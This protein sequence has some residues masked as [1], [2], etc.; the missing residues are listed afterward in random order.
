VLANQ[1][2][3]S[4]VMIVKNGLPY[5]AEALQSIESQSYRNFELVIQDGASTDGTLDALAAARDRGRIPAI[6]TE[7]APDRGVADAFNKAVN[8]CNGA[9]IGSIDADNLLEPTCLET[10]VRRFA[11][12]PRAAVIYGAQKMVHENGAFA[13]HFH[14]GPFNP[15]DVLDCRL[16]PPFGSSFFRK[17][18][19]AQR[20]FSDPALKTC[21]DFNIWLNYFDC[22]VVM[23][24]DVLVSTRM[25]DSSMT[26]RPQSYEQFCQDKIAACNRFFHSLERNAITDRLQ[27]RSIAGIYLWA[28]E[29]LRFMIHSPIARDMH[30]AFLARAKEADPLH[31]R[32]A[33]FQR[34]VDAEKPPSTVP[35]PPRRSAFHLTRL[36]VRRGLDAIFGARS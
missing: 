12:Y 20:L 4:L 25:S 8:R 5:I 26:F 19:S 17:A 21:A 31:P 27:R 23:V 16:V 32:L 9:I 29:S 11:D 3:I 28:A 2:L 1:P 10:V 36:A 24:P 33:E 18:Q 13:H 7:S 34:K 22:E 30:A 15:L 6:L 14:P 35:P